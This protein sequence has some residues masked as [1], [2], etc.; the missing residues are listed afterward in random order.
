MAINIQTLLDVINAK[1]TTGVASG[2]TD[3]DRL[4]ELTAWRDNHQNAGF[5]NTFA[6]LPTA[7]SANAGEFRRVGSDSDAAYYVSWRNKWK[8]ITFTDSDVSQSYS[9]YT[10]QGSTSGYISGGATPTLQNAILKFSFTSD[11]NTSD[12][13]DLTVTRT[14]V[15]GQSSSDNGYTSG[16]SAPPLTPP[17]QNV[18]DKF[19][20]PSD[21]NAT[22]VG[23]LTVARSNLAGHSSAD[24][25]YTSGGTP[26]AK[27][28]IDKF[29]FSSDGNA[30][31]VGDLTASRRGQAGQSSDVSGYA[32]GGGYPISNVIDKFPFSSDANATDVG[33]ITLGRYLTTG[34]SSTVSGYVSGGNSPLEPNAHPPGVAKNSIEKF[35]FASDA[36]A[37]DIADLTAARFWLVGQSSTASGYASGGYNPTSLYLNVIDKFPFSSDANATDVGDVGGARGQAAGQQV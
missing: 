10:F 19:P 20:F 22:D 1:I 16:G 23:D 36:N 27:N 2:S 6:D 30:T 34:Q 21:A 26:G 9:T 11:G 17:D 33:D 37:T 31:D 4:V 5:F 12:V 25:G 3:S 28:E 13:G 8:E 24:N 15:T 14:L 29:P 32:S 7:D 18:I 35:P